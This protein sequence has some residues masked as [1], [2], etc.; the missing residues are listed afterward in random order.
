MDKPKYKTIIDNNFTIV[1]VCRG[2]RSYTECNKSYGDCCNEY[3]YQLEPITNINNDTDKINIINSNKSI[4]LSETILIEDEL[5]NS[6]LSN[7]VTIKELERGKW[8]TH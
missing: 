3:V 2:D 4:A 6:H 8:Q 1:C 5:Y 7:T